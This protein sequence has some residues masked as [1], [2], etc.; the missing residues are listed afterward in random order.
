[1]ADGS[2]P[3]PGPF[4]QRAIDLHAAAGEDWVRRLPTI[5]ASCA[6]QWSL[7]VGTTFQ[8]LSYSYV[9]PAM[10]ADGTRAVLK[11]GFPDQALLWEAE[12]LRLFVGQGAARLLAADLE[13]G[14]LLLERLEPGASLDSLDDDEAATAIAA[15]VMS[16][17]WRPVP[18]EHSFPSV[19]D[20]A[21]D[22]GQVRKRFG[23]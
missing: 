5:I 11:I 13:Q 7:S 18:A 20:W 10:R 2:L 9:V 17:L 14:A 8:L 4:L 3:L 23:G 19:T 21:A 12:A 6:R 16:Q 22:L 1:M 15:R